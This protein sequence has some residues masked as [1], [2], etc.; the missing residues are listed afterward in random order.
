MHVIT[1]LMLSYGDITVS[2]EYTTRRSH[3]LPHL[4]RL[5]CHLSN[6]AEEVHST[7]RL[8]T[9]VYL[10]RRPNITATKIRKVSVTQSRVFG[11]GPQPLN[12]L[13][14]SAEC[15]PQR[16]EIRRDQV[17]L[18]F[19]PF[20]TCSV[21]SHLFSVISS[22]CRMLPTPPFALLPVA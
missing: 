10:H 2:G 6:Q 7:F 16:A 15:L 5:S 13:N 21:I 9:V 17:S 14:F 11:V 3:P 20:T 18:S 19:L 8:T 4:E 1:L 12:L 22:Q